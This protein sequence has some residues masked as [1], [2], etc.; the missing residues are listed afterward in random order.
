MT[1]TITSNSQ[2]DENKKGIPLPSGYSERFKE[3][4]RNTPLP[5]RIPEDPEAATG[6]TIPLSPDDLPL[7]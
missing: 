2:E 1:E 7:Q 3:R 6:I 4:M 5:E